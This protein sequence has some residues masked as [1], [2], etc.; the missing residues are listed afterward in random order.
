[1]NK[2]NIII[3]TLNKL[4][5]TQVC[6]DS[7]RRFTQ[8]G[9]YQIIVVDNGSTDG[10]REWLADQT[11][12]M[13]IFNEDNVGF[14]KGCNQG[15]NVSGAGDILLLNN[16]V[17]VTP[18]WLELLQ[19]CLHSSP[20][21][22]AVAP[23]HNGEL[24]VRYDSVEELWE[25]AADYNNGDQAEWEERLKLLGFSMLIKREVLEQVGLLDE[26]F[27]PGNCE[28]TD[29]S[30]RI[31]SQG[32]KNIYCKN[33]YIHHYGSVSFGEMK[34]EYNELLKVNR[35]KFVDKWGFH[36]VHHSV[37]RHDLINLIDQKDP[38]NVFTILD[39]GCGCGATLLE[40]KNRYPQA[41]RFGIERNAQAAA[42]AK[43][44]ATV[45][46]IDIESSALEFPEGSMDYIIL[47]SVLE[48]MIDP[49]S[50]LKKLGPLLKPE[51]RII[52]SIANVMHYSVI[53]SLIKGSWSYQ[54]TGPM[55]R[56]NLRHFAKADALRLFEDAGCKS[57]ELFPVKHQEKPDTLA[58]VDKFSDFVHV[59]EKEQ[60]LVTHYLFKAA[61]KSNS[62]D[63][64]LIEIEKRLY[65]IS[66]DKKLKEQ[67]LSEIVELMSNQQIQSQDLIS[68][69]G[70]IKNNEVYLLNLLARTF[71]K[72][73]LFN[74]VIPLLNASLELDSFHPDTLYN[75][76]FILHQVGA[77]KEALL[78]LERMKEMDDE[79]QQLLQRISSAV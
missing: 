22:G 45:A 64:R 1:M 70:R 76:A 40:V 18:R 8:R 29:Y 7:I 36:S 5:Y 63:D 56:T 72:H 75:Y 79:A 77:D 23:N 41:L 38:E 53:N 39:V 71:Y 26:R 21:I 35:E 30:L 46:V 20:D 61:F 62:D 2:T 42:I 11:D 9:S 59:E 19:A 37:T 25:F 4:E 58:W 55:R 13:S 16:D 60:L 34:E 14:P 24:E 28:D 66:R 51:G 47:G 6:I 33:I 17:I 65:D 54:E 48:E 74:D 69:A 31:I 27:T 57:L 32:Y 3:L 52:A 78:Y 67:Y 44:F 10:T 50:V 68:V 43:Q 15:I 73:G 49:V 12:I